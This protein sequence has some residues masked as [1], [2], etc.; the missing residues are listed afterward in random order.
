M[1]TYKGTNI[2]KV[3]ANAPII[4]VLNLLRELHWLEELRG[5][6]G[7]EGKMIG[8]TKLGKVLVDDDASLKIPI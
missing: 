4:L 5:K 2:G 3:T 6:N 1:V 8:L 7:R